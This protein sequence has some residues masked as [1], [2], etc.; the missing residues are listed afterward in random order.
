[1][2]GNTAVQDQ[3]QTVR[4][5][6][7]DIIDAANAVTGE[8]MGQIANLSESGF[9]LI[10]NRPMAENSL[11]QIS[12]SVGLPGDAMFE[13]SVGAQVLWCSPAK[14]ADSYWAGFQIVDISDN[15][16]EALEAL[17]KAL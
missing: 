1:M 17:V 10:A 8:I 6:L 2:K 14:V 15:D 5:D 12:F 11:Y 4:K 3:R 7:P 9:M 13:F 16:Y